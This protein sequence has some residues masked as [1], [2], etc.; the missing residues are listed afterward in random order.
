MPDPPQVPSADDTGAQPA[1]VT[2]SAPQQGEAPGVS[3]LPDG[4]VTSDHVVTSDQV[5]AP[6]EP[7]PLDPDDTE[8]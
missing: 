6:G 8:H 4:D 7:A 5:V 1:P 2:G 3:A